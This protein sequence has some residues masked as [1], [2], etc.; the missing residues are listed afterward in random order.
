MEYF[1]LG[2][3]LMVL[4]AVA[5]FIFLYNLLLIIINKIKKG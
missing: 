3:Y 5:T 2:I 4:I 1:I